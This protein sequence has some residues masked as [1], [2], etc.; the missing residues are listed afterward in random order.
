M[1]SYA[2]E[3]VIF[4]MKHPLVAFV[5]LSAISPHAQALQEKYLAPIQAQIDSDDC[6][7]GLRK[8][9]KLQLEHIKAQSLSHEIILIQSIGFSL[10]EQD[11]LGGPPNSHHT[12]KHLT[13]R[14]NM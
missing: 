3:K 13:Q 11:S 7:P 9:Y 1:P 8:Q 14:E 10:G 2:G 12:Q 4:D 6:P 5:P